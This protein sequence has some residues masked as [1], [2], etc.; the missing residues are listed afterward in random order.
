MLNNLIHNDTPISYATIIVYAIPDGKVKSMIS[1][2]DIGYSNHNFYEADDITYKDVIQAYN[3][4]IR[5]CNHKG[6]NLKTNVSYAFNQGKI[7]YLYIDL[8]SD[9][10]PMSNNDW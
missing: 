9:M 7:D 4:I 6:I 8:D 1:F 3:S 10:L 5:Y 2:K